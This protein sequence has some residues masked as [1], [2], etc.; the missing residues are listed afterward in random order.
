MLDPEAHLRRSTPAWERAGVGLLRLL[1]GDDAVKDAV[2][3]EKAGRRGR[4]R[5]KVIVKYA[6][7]GI[8]KALSDETSEIQ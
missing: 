6:V 3:V 7:F 1:P 2:F 4:G 8:T 5:S